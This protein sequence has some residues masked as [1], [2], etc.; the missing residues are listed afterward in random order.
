MTVTSDI[1]LA[2]QSHVVDPENAISILKQIVK[3]VNG[4]IDA[5][6]DIVTQ[7]ARGP[8]GISGTADDIIPPATIA[9]LQALLDS[10][11]VGKVAVELSTFSPGRTLSRFWPCCSISTL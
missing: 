7:L 3:L 9:A 8:D 1:L 6:V 4:D 2:I 10:D 11:L 5:A